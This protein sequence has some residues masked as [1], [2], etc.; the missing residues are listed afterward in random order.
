MTPQTEPAPRRPARK[1][2]NKVAVVTGASKGIGASIA[3]EL[4]RMGLR[5][6][7]TTP[8]ARRAPTRSWPRLRRR[9]APPGRWAATWSSGRRSRSSSPRRKGLRQGRHPREQRRRLPLCSAGRHHG[10]VCRR[11]VRRQRDGAAVAT[12]A[13]VAMFPPEGGSVINIGSG[14]GEYPAGPGRRVQ[15]HQGAVNSITRSLARELGPR[16]IRVNALNP[17]YRR[18]RRPRSQQNRGKRMGKADGARPAARSPGSRRDIASVAAFLA[19]DEASGSPDRCSMPRADCAERPSARARSRRPARCRR[20]PP[21]RQRAP[22]RR[23][24]AD[25]C[26]AAR[27]APSD[28]RCVR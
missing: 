2:A 7:S 20:A 24:G 4:R 13:A 16:K 15:R 6:S 27:A 8:R 14:A 19:S 18:H 25:P 26:E 3:K 5:S 22:C 12:K 21:G 9:A 11:D 17:A 23:R 1:L 28:V 10:R